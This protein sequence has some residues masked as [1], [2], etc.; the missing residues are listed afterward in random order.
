MTA[1]KKA[2]KKAAKRVLKPLIKKLGFIDEDDKNRLQ[3]IFFNNLK[4]VGFK[5]KHIV[6]IGANKGTW[7]REIYKV[8]PNSYYSLIEPQKQLSVHFQDILTK[9]NVVFYPF[10]VGSKSGVFKFTIA[11]RDDSCSFNYSEKQAKEL[12]FNQVDIEIKTLNELLVNNSDWPIPDI[13]KIDA[14]GLDLEVLK[15][16]SDF[17]GKTEIFLVEAAVYEKEFEN[18]VANVISYMDQIGYKL[19]EITDLNRPFS[20]ALLWLIELVFIKKEGI[21]DSYKMPTND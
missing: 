9:P 6:D 11:N 14:E 13:I 16:A 18:T 10:G 15:G 8:F 19:F 20:P 21:I 12:G 4:K 17:H 7:T 1:L 2:I 5:P 3:H